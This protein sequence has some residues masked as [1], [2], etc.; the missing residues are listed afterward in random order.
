MQELAHS[1]NI[2]LSAELT[3]KVQSVQRLLGDKFLELRNYDSSPH[4]AVA[5]KFMGSDLTPDFIEAL[6]V[7]FSKEKSFDI[8]FTSFAPAETGNYIFLNLDTESREKILTLSRRA[9]QATKGI[10]FEG[11][12]GTAPKYPYDPHISIIKLENGNIDKALSLINCDFSS[13][14]MTVEGFELTRESLN[15]QGFGEFPIVARINLEKWN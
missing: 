8:T 5:T 12:G 11:H 15:E 6:K 7:E 4:L 2:V 1:F 14:T 9:F 3:S 10:G 13:I